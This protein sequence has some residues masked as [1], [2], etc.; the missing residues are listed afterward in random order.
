MVL[1][2][3][4]VSPAISGRV[5]TCATT[6]AVTVQNIA[7]SWC[8]HTYGVEPRPPI[9]LPMPPVAVLRRLGFRPAPRF[10]CVNRLDV[11]DDGTY[12]RLKAPP[13]EPQL[14][15]AA[16]VI[17]RVSAQSCFSAVRGLRSVEGRWPWSDCPAPGRLP[18]LSRGRGGALDTLEAAVRFKAAVERARRAASPLDNIYLRRGQA[19]AH[20]QTAPI[21]AG[22]SRNAAVGRAAAT[23]G[24]R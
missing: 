4:T 9:F 3:S 5:L 13:G 11:S 24:V 6:A 14:G 12:F 10:N 1:L 19:P 20:R 23:S 15:L 18:S 21:L 17:H 2:V 8:M 7:E 16:G 22:A